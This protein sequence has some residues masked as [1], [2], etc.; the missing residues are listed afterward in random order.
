MKCNKES[1][2]WYASDSALDGA[3]CL[4]ISPSLKDAMI[5]CVE[6][7]QQ[8][9]VNHGANRANSKKSQTN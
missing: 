3:V 2:L 8:R 7:M 1:G 9:E 5:Y 6:S 4:G